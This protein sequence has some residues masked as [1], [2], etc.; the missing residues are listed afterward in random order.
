MNYFDN[1]TT[2]HCGPINSPQVRQ[3]IFI[4]FRYGPAV[5]NLLFDQGSIKTLK[6]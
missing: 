5:A 4:P 1:K 6:V 3:T 2:C